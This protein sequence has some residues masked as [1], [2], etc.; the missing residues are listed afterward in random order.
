MNSVQLHI[1][2]HDAVEK[3]GCSIICEDRL[4]NVLLDYGAFID[5]PAIKNILKTMIA[6][7]YCQKVLDLGRRKRFSLTSLLNQPNKIE[8]P[9]GEEWKTKVQS[10][11]VDYARQNGYLQDLVIYTTDSILYALGWK[12]NEPDN[13][14]VSKNVKSTRSVSSQTGAQSTAVNNTTI[15]SNTSGTNTNLSNS[16]TYQT[17]LNTQF[18]VINVKPL[19]AEVFIDGKQ[20]YVSNGISAVELTIGKHDYEVR[21]NSYETQKGTIDIN[22]S[23]KQTLDIALKLQQALANLT[24][25][26]TDADAEI[27]ADGKHLGI[28]KWSGLVKSGDI[29]IEC[30]KDKCYPYTIKQTISSGKDN[31]VKIPNLQ[32]ICGNIKINVQPYGSKIFINGKEEG[33]TPLMVT[34]IQI[35]ERMLRVLTSEGQDYVTTVDVRENKVTDIN[36]II[37]SLFLDDYSQLEIGDWYYEDGSFSHVKAEGKTAVGIV[38]SLVTSE[39]EKIRGWTHGQIV[40]VREAN[41]YKMFQ[42]KDEYRKWG[43]YSEAIYKYAV[44][45]IK[46]IELCMPSYS[47][48]N[49]SKYDKGYAATHEESIFD[50]KEYPIFYAASHHDAP[51]PKG[52]TSG[53][54]LPSI[55]Q[56]HLLSNVIKTLNFSWELQK[57]LKLDELTHI[58]TSSMATE[59]TA[60]GGIIGY[61][62]TNK[63]DSGWFNVRPVA[64]F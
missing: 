18:L 24:V 37:P 6:D 64:S 33:T 55:Y 14:G 34:G 11:C 35:G 50:N 8:K 60:W 1:A 51:L 54:Y 61:M 57:E 30:R 29:T 36:H 9:Q 63:L 16:I 10:Y 62:R 7:G 19:N 4:V 17:I 46:N 20:Q 41:A 31:I 58:S 32:P 59:D 26:C 44:T 53:W 43:L 2:L 39:E 45:T 52:K 3:F 47:K 42:G 12:T 23:S 40:A 5:N 21:S 48:N 15:S 13:T 27:L 56:A 49:Y 22:A 25:E 28:G 38:F